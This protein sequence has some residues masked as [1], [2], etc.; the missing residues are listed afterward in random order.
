[1]KTSSELQALAMLIY[2]FMIVVFFFLCVL[3]NK[4]WLGIVMLV[5]GIFVAYYL[6]KDKYV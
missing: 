4:L 5:L 6:T 1:M 3:V 2:L